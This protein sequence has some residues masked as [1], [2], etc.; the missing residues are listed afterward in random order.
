MGSEAWQ[1]Q[2]SGNISG[3]GYGQKLYIKDSKGGEMK[4]IL[5]QVTEIL[6]PVCGNSSVELLRVRKQIDQLYRKEYRE[7]LLE[8]TSGAEDWVAEVIKQELSDE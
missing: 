1:V 2:S 3:N 4:D 5:E 7:R 8:V 6:E